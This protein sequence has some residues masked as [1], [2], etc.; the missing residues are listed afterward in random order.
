MQTSVPGVFAA[1]DCR[2]GST[3]QAASAAG[4]GAAAALA[5]RRYIQPLTSGMPD[6][7]RMMESRSSRLM[8]PARSGLAYIHGTES[9]GEESEDIAVNPL[10]SKLTRR[11]LLARYGA[12][13]RGLGTLAIAGCG[14]DDDEEVSTATIAS[15]IPTTLPVTPT[16][17]A[18]ATL[19]WTRVP[20]QSAP[21]ARRD[22]SLTFNPDDGLIYLFGGRAKGLADNELWTFDPGTAAWTQVAA[23]GAPEPRFAHNAFYDRT[24]KRLIVTLGQGNDGAFFDDVWA[25]G[26]GA[27]TRLDADS[28]ARPEI[29]YGSG[30]AHDVAGNRILISHGF[31]DRG[32]FDDTWTFDL[33]TRRLAADRDDRGCA[34]QALPHALPL[35][36]GIRLDA[37]VRRADRQ[38]SIPRRLLD[39]RCCEGRDGRSRPRA[40][41]GPAQ[42][43]RCEPRRRWQTLV[44]RR[45]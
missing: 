11:A 16:A 9:P 44:H 30:G 20:L 45:R 29:R 42:P 18:P 8:E 17:A 3:K 34:D 14:G 12:R 36:A 4:E 15:A 35:A 10:S 21:G 7:G 22:H 33:A 40:V 32:R 5:I 43:L 6:H 37:D 26:A 41:A 27:W 31:T 39:A 2:E 24:A 25:Y 1:G 23:A 28:A 19:S 13:R 38:Q